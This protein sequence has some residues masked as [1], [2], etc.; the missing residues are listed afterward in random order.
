MPGV[1]RQDVERIART[2]LRELGVE[3]P[4]RAVVMEDDQPGHWRIEFDGAHGRTR[5]R[6]KGGPGTTPQWMR[7]QIFKQYLAQT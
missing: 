1:E 2:A 3:G 5:L 7:E 6:V 4:E